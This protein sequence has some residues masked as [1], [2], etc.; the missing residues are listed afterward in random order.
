MKIAYLILAHRDIKHLN[1]LITALDTDNT[2]F[3]IHIDRKSSISQNDVISKSNIITFSTYKIYWGGWN[4]V[5]ASLELLKRAYINDHDRYIFISG[6]DYPII[7]NNKIIDFL[8][9]DKNH[10]Y[11]FTNE[12][13]IQKKRFRYQFFYPM[14]FFKGSTKVVWRFGQL[15]SFLSKM[16]LFKVKKLG[17]SKKICFG[18]QWGILTNTT[19]GKLLHT[20]EAFPEI[21]NFFRYSFIPDEMFYQ[22][23]LLTYL[24]EEN[25]NNYLITFQKWDNELTHPTILT[26]KEVDII[27]ESHKIFIRKCDSI[28]S[29]TL[30]DLIDAQ[31]K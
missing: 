19:T 14:D 1:R 22:T 12:T 16:G 6:Q 29:R 20:I 17:D 9:Q 24:P 27:F 26:E 2:T 7:S 5:Q 18:S 4:M 3:Y 30:L 25:I 31:R 10:F 11:F 8:R 28:Q 15:H 23:L 13:E 21:L